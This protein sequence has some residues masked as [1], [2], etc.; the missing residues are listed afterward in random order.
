MGTPFMKIRSQVRELS[1]EDRW[2]FAKAIAFEEAL[3]LVGGDGGYAWNR[4]SH[5]LN[6]AMEFSI[7]PIMGGESQ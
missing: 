4:V 7:P 2:M 6:E 3:R 5:A 1:A